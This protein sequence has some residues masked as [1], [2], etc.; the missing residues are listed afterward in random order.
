MLLFEYY[1]KSIS[2]HQCWQTL[3]VPSFR[4][5]FM[6]QTKT[7]SLC[8][9]WS[10]QTKFDRYNSGS[11]A[12]RIHRIRSGRISIDKILISEINGNPEVNIGTAICTVR[13]LY[14]F[15]RNIILVIRYYTIWCQL[16]RSWTESSH[17]LLLRGIISKNQQNRANLM[18]TDIIIY[19]HYRLKKHERIFYLFF[20]KL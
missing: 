10:K 17:P 1:C 19:F 20:L 16:V 14:S 6:S 18:K 12:G 11:H 9:K 4:G 2:Y 13:L 8:G 15:R 7:F 5:C 3:K